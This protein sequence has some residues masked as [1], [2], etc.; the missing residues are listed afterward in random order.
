MPVKG[1]ISIFFF[2]YYFY[3]FFNPASIRLPYDIVQYY[4]I[5]LYSMTFSVNKYHFHNLNVS[6]IFR[7]PPLVV[8]RYNRYH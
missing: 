4:S 5:F 1:K 2:F 7:I 3:F 6:R 8:K